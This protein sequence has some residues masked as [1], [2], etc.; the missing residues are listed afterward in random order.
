MDKNIIDALKNQRPGDKIIK[1]LSNKFAIVQSSYTDGTFDDDDSVCGLHNGTIYFYGKLSI[2]NNFY[3]NIVEPMQNEYVT[4]YFDTYSRKSNGFLSYD[5]KVRFVKHNR[6]KMQ[7]R[8][9][10]KLLS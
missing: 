10:L 8:R 4:T 9:I 3:I 6:Y 1:I 5:Y 7:Y 2:I